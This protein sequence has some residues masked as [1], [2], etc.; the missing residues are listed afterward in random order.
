M[1]KQQILQIC[2][3]EIAKSRNN[4]QQIATNNLM[5]ARSIP[6]FVEIE[7]QE[8]MLTF[9]I[10]KLK[11][12]GE[13]CKNKI[14]KLKET[15]KNKQEL[16][17]K[18]NIQPDSLIPNYSCKLC[19]D[20]GYISGTICKCL[21]EKM[22]KKLLES[23]GV[24]EKSLA[25][26]DQLDHTIA[27]SQTHQLQLEKIKKYLEN[28]CQDYPN[29]KIR[30]IVLSGKTG[31]GKTFLSECLANEFLKK[32]Y[33]ASFITAFALGNIMLSYHTCFDSQKQSYLDAVLEPDL[34]VIDDLG[35]EPIFKNV[36]IEYLY[37]VL[38][39]RACKNKITLITTNLDLSAILSRYN[40]RIF[41][42][43][44]NKR[45]GLMTFIDGSDLRLK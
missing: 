40:E 42:R 4:A 7:K 26:F 44:A 43:L 29:T 37:L 33:M 45:T 17:E 8:R 2:L 39:E 13:D 1:N 15:Q 5:K 18:N 36:T 38:N 30:S 25:S 34:L 16:L 32:G 21:S 24:S 22:H 23:C 20:T 6:G 28:L 41:S 11:A 3:N 19:E 9:E 35:T 12:L 10:G 27:K 31:V 14:L